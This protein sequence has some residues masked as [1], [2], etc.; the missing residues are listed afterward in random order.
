[1]TAFSQEWLQHV[2]RP[3]SWNTREQTRLI[4]LLAGFLVLFAGVVY[5]LQISAVASKRHDLDELLS[6]RNALER[7]VEMLREAITVGQNLSKLQQRA[8]DL[9]FRRASKDEI[10]YLNIEGYYIAN[11]SVSDGGNPYS[12][13]EESDQLERTGMRW[14]DDFRRQWLDFANP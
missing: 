13:L 7:E 2:F 6:Q 12:F 1:M 14:L 11:P 3:S 4:L 9:G 10:R 5:V 8:L